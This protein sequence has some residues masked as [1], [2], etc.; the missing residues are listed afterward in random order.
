MI[1]YVI[2]ILKAYQV[3]VQITFVLLNCLKAEKNQTCMEAHRG[4]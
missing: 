3:R 1:D 4:A 2:Y